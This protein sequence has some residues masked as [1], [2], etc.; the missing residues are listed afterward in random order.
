MP[1]KKKMPEPEDSG[2]VTQSIPRKRKSKKNQ[3]EAL[4]VAESMPDPSNPN[5]V[6][7]HLSDGRILAITEKSQGT[8]ELYLNML[9]A[10]MLKSTVD[11]FKITPA[12]DMAVYLPSSY[13]FYIEIV[14]I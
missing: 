3:D 14:L 12:A 4:V 5:M 11:E 13:V 9:N 6:L 8:E 2:I 1:A 7:A 10:Y